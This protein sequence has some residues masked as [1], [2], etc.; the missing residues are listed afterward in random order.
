M[1]YTAP[2][3]SSNFTINQPG[4]IYNDLGQQIGTFPGWSPGGDLGATYSNMK[5]TADFLGTANLNQ[6]VAQMWD[7]NTGKILQQPRSP[8]EAAALQRQ[9]EQFAATQ[10]QNT[11][12]QAMRL[13][14]GG[15]L[16]GLS[17]GSSGAATDTMKPI[18][19]KFLSGLTSTLDNP[20]LSDSAV[21][22]IVSRGQEEINAT[23]KDT[24][25]NML[26][27]ALA[28]GARNAGDTAY[29][30]QRLADQAGRQ[31]AGL[32][33]DV[34]IA[35]EQERNSQR[36]AGLGVAGN[37]LGRVEDAARADRN[38]L[39]EL[40]LNQKFE[41]PNLSNL[42]SMAGMG[43]TG[44]GTTS[45]NSG[46]G[47][48]SGGGTASGSNNTK[49]AFQTWTNPTTTYTPTAR[50]TAPAAA[51]VDDQARSTA[52]PGQNQQVQKP[53]TGG[54]GGSRL[55]GNSDF[56]YDPATGTYK[57]VG[58]K[59]VKLGQVFRYD[60]QPSLDPTTLPTKK[61]SAL[62]LRAQNLSDWLGPS[63]IRT[64]GGGTGK[65][66]GTAAGAATPSLA[67]AFGGGSGGGYM[68]W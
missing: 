34:R 6:R 8:N 13:L 35:A 11:R 26:D 49:P 61:P 17:G 62:G 2:L 45:V 65:L 28:S 60:G 3:Y 44:W 56:Q 27:L 1:G 12:N 14:G 51:P 9:L 30:Q 33:R 18:R 7:P 5:Q 19:D 23:N 50:V 54:G 20:G 58:T 47:A 38:Q 10:A 59:D 64:V 29:G 31:R 68:Q 21:Q 25:A 57:Y 67:G 22:G 36:L 53:A 66:K 39:M 24:Q 15:T 63:G 42:S 46:G 43:S 32:G 55:A 48:N 52:R 16:G 37:Y 4:Q 41:T 40:L